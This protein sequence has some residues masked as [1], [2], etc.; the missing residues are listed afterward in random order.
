ME[1]KMSNKINY[2][3]LRSL[4]STLDGNPDPLS[5]GNEEQNAVTTEPVTVIESGPVVPPERKRKLTESEQDDSSIVASSSKKFKIAKIK[6][7]S[8]AEIAK[9]II[10]ETIV[11]QI[12]VVAAEPESDVVVES[13]PVEV[14]DYEEESKSNL[15]RVMKSLIDSNF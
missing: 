12:P 11:E 10:K 9:T 1:R 6:S 14:D 13:G 15:K 5:G 4:T 7:E 2:D 8:K 3:V